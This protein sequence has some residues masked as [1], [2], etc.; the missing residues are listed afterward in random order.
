[1]RLSDREK[2]S[3]LFTAIDRLVKLFESMLAQ[4]EICRRFAGS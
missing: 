3:S 4:A 2:A 1:M